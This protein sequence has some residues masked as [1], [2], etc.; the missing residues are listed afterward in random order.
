MGILPC[1]FESCQGDEDED[2]ESGGGMKE[3][4]TPS[5]TSEHRP[6]WRP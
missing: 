2:D 3:V 4:D 6:D 1:P 5:E